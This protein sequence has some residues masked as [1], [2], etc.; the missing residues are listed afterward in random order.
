M[1]W[2]I[3]TNRIGWPDFSLLLFPAPSLDWTDE[4]YNFEKLQTNLVLNRQPLL[5]PQPLGLSP[6][7][8]LVIQSN[9]DVFR[10][11]GFEF[12][13]DNEGKLLLSAVPFSK[14]V[15]F[16]VDDVVELVGLLDGSAADESLASSVWLG[17]NGSSRMVLRPSRVRA[18]L[19]SRACRSSIMIGRALD[20]RTM[21]RILKNLSSLQSPW[22][23]PHG[24][25][26]MRHLAVLNYGV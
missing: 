24:R 17:M 10:K 20:R 16:G 26:T 11:N 18:M 13:T 19:A 22:N 8:A 14:G 1:G 5:H 25:P 21:Q 4:K 6:A 23:C 15:T 9:L 3:S 2:E 7:E 12:V